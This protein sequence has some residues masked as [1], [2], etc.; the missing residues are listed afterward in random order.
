MKT[1]YIIGNGFDLWH[2][3]PTSYRQFYDF[4]QDILDEV[5]EHYIFNPSRDIPWYDFENALGTFNADGFFDYH[6]EIDVTAEDFRSS[7]AFA[8]EDELVEASERHV[9]T[10][11]DAFIEWIDQIDETQ[12]TIKMKFNDNAIFINFNYTSTLQAVYDIEDKDILHIH[13]CAKKYDELIFGHGEEITSNPEIDEN[14]DSN[15]TMFSDAES[16][17]KYPLYAFKKPVDE[18]IKNMTNYFEQ[19]GDVTEIVIIGHSLNKIDLPYFCRI[20]EKATGAKWNVACYTESDKTYYLQA[21]INCG[22]S[23]DKINTLSY[24]DL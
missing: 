10:I 16:A 5:E 20:S 3:L 6:N 22:I 1:L 23:Q 14:G 7:F 2:G 4:A 8:L 13:G 9:T 15:R 11:K 17:A 12:A 18:I 21:L 19:L 24:N